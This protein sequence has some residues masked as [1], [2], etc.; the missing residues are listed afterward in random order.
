[1]ALKFQYTPKL[2][3]YGT[4]R[5][6]LV[7]VVFTNPTTKKNI[8]INCLIDSGADGIVL[9]GQ[10]ADLLNLRF[11]SGKE[12]RYQGITYEPVIAYDHTL[13][14]YLNGDE[15]HKFNVVCSFLP[16]LRTAGLLGQAGF[17]DNYKVT[18]ERYKKT[19]QLT[20]R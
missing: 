19:F 1:M 5:V 15:K 13:S 9:N 10:F 3:N 4:G 8:K 7:E 17:F 16:G 20:P 14:M 6:P 12:H 11:T 18:F 2:T